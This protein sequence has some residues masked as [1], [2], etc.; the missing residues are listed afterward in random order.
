MLS[1]NDW[2]MGNA[3][4]VVRFS[5]RPTLSGY[6]QCPAWH[7]AMSFSLLLFL[8]AFYSLVFYSCSSGFWGLAEHKLPNEICLCPPW[9]PPPLPHPPPP[10][11][12]LYV[13]PGSLIAGI[14]T[15]LGKT[16]LLSKFNSSIQ[17]FDLQRTL[18]QYW[19]FGIAHA[20]LPNYFSSSAFFS[21]LL[22]QYFMLHVTCTFMS[23]VMM[24]W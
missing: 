10:T 17:F 11:S 16:R 5:V 1:D 22:V 6:W 19:V 7:N 23:F 15:N 3:L 9:V 21:L 2:W 20:F 12:L 4:K 24:R 14:L 18:I 13:T 8:L